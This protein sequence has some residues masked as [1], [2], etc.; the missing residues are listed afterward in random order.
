MPRT[1]K[2]GQSKLVHDKKKDIFIWNQI[3]DSGNLDKKVAMIKKS[4]CW[5]DVRNAYK[6][7]KNGYLKEGDK[8]HP[9]FVVYI[10]AVNQIYHAMKQEN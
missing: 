6:K 7:L 5:N 9:S 4:G 3:R 1:E 8:Y 10:Q 2:G